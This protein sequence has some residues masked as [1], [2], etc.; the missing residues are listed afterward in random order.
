VVLR[1]WCRVVSMRSVVLLLWCLSGG[2]AAMAVAIMGLFTFFVRP[3]L[4]V[5]LGANLV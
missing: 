5:S 4:I 1:F 2:G 3:I